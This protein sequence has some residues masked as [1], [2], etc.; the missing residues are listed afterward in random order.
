MQ[1][2]KM[3]LSKHL[4]QVKVSERAARLASCFFIQTVWT[5][6]T[7]TSVLAVLFLCSGPLVGNLYL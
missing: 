5:R 7:N 3:P 1:D 4:D 6:D 2:I